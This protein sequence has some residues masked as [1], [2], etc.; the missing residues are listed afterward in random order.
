MCDNDAYH[1]VAFKMTGNSKHY[2]YLQKK[3]RK[4][5][6]QH[7]LVSH[8]IAK[9]IVSAAELKSTESVYE[10]GT[11]RGILTAMM[12][13][14]AG[15]VLSVDV[16][17]ELVKQA[18]R[19]LSKF[20]NLQIECADGFDLMKKD[21]ED[22]ASEVTMRVRPYCDVFVSNLPYSRSRRAIE[23]LASADF[24]RCIIMIQKEFA[25]KILAG[26]VSE[27]D[28][29][30][31]RAISIIAQ[32]CFEIR[33]VLGVPA[34]CFEPRPKVDSVVVTLTRCNTLDSAQIRM[35]NKIFS[36]R[37]K[38]LSSL[39]RLLVND[40]DGNT[41]YIDD[42][43]VHHTHGHTC[44]PDNARAFNPDSLKSQVSDALGRDADALRLD[45][46]TV[47]DIIRLTNILIS[48]TCRS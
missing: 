38:R 19:T 29:S 26:S 41:N 37:R 36:Y 17:S 4:K 15:R 13:Q 3:K 34:R 20:E 31:R 12:C 47:S 23:E 1:I 18:R 24:K 33:T 9:N 45:D 22:H 46:L 35:I 11:G 43:D 39:L 6:G 28:F 42:G 5:L 14:K 21:F 27:H 2:N 40:A 32:H 8:H 25:S 10:L 44:L 16:D 30:S 7:F 48:H